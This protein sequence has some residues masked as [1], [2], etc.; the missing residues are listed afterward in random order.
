MATMSPH[1]IQLHRIPAALLRARSHGPEGAAAVDWRAIVVRL[2][3]EATPDEVRVDPG[4]W[5][6]WRRLLPHV[7]AAAG[8]DA[9]LAT[10]PTEA[11]RLL[12]R[13]ATYLLIC[14]ELQT[15]VAVHQRAYTVRRDTSAAASTATTTPTLCV[16]PAFSALC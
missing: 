9:A 2:L 13:A 15:A 12:D 11:T 16:P 6:L 5:P 14:G 8:H 1:E 4:G 10:I 3:D 7:L